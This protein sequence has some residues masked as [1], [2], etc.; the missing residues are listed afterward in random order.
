MWRVYIAICFRG[1]GGSTTNQKGLKP[2]GFGIGYF[3]WIQARHGKLHRYGS[4][5]TCRFQATGA[6]RA[7]PGGGKRVGPK[8]GPKRAMMG[9]GGLVGAVS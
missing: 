3:T 4:L 9:D 1:V 2:K 8:R 5:G 7:V 6:Q